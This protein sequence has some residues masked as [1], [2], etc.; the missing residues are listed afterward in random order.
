MKRKDFALSILALTLGGTAFARGRH[1]R[2]RNSRN[3]GRNSRGRS[4]TS[5]K[6]TDSPITFT[7]VLESNGDKL[8]I[9]GS[10]MPIEV[11]K[12]MSFLAKKHVGK[13]V[14]VTGTK[15]TVNGKSKVRVKFIKPTPQNY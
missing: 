15:I 7:G 11:D 12:G 14:K 10:D 1:S 4:R 5:K 6:I 2:G 3:R 13:E 8:S 9:S